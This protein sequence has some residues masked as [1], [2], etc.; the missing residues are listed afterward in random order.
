MTGVE[1]GLD[2][3]RFRN[4]D[5]EIPKLIIG[6]DVIFILLIARLDQIVGAKGLVGFVWLIIAQVG[7]LGAVA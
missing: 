5:E 3:H 7:H 1:I 2:E 4:L 6:D